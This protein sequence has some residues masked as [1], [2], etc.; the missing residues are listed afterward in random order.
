MDPVF[1]RTHHSDL[2]HLKP[3]HCWSH[4]CKKGIEEGR[5]IHGGDKILKIFLMH[6]DEPD[7][8]ED[9]IVY[10]S[11]LV[12]F[13]NLHIVDNMSGIECTRIFERYKP[14]GLNILP[15]M[16]DLNQREHFI[17]H[18]MREQ[19]Q[20]CDFMIKL[21]T[22][23][24]LA[25]TPD[26]K[27]IIN[28]PIKFKRFVND[29]PIIPNKYKACFS[30]TSLIF[31]EDYIYPAQE[32]TF[33]QPLT[34]TAS[35][36]FF[37]SATF[38]HCDLGG[39]VGKVRTPH[40]DNCVDINLV[41]IHLNRTSYRRFIE[42]SYE[43]VFSHGY[44]KP[45]DT[46][47]EQKNKLRTY[48]NNKMGLSIHKVENVLRH[49]EGKTSVHTFMDNPKYGRKMEFKMLEYVHPNY[50]YISEKRFK[51]LS[52]IH[53]K[54]WKVDYV[55]KK[56]ITVP[57]EEPQNASIFKFH[58]GGE[59]TQP[60]KKN[61]NLLSIVCDD[62][63]TNTVIPIEAKYLKS[64]TQH[65]GWH[66]YG[67]NEGKVRIDGNDGGWAMFYILPKQN[68]HNIYLQWSVPENN[69]DGTFGR[70]I[71]MSPEGDFHSNGNNGLWAEFRL[72]EVK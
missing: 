57:K 8:L 6:K 3:E 48:T 33:F 66:I 37:P 52:P 62:N 21:D 45:T 63:Q 26:G 9:W 32:I 39:H 47:E 13:N 44:I 12:G 54:F 16:T 38:E 24:F 30:T 61:I 68:S 67:D 56:L 69:V 60:N 49:L 20:F 2:S 71:W 35:K 15:T 23:E 41:W 58:I 72:I 53:K 50:T 10:H 59:I 14:Y 29:I 17:S 46:P 64:D 28:E 42:K 36:S 31:K 4:F 19:A 34:R 65:E 25:F 43:V 51:I 1:Y 11:K 27:K 70:H 7:L 22:D 5:K 40:N 55:E 18:K